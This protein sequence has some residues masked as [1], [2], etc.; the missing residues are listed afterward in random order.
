ML[1]PLKGERGRGKPAV[2]VSRSTGLD[3]GCLSSK[4]RAVGENR[5]A[6]VHRD[7]RRRASGAD[8]YAG[9]G[10]RRA[11]AGK[12]A[13]PLARRERFSVARWRNRLAQLA[14][15]NA[16]R[17]ARKGRPDRLLDL[18]LHQLAPL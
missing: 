13:G 7:A 15:A 12:L 11:P 1:L 6:R 17:T 18:Y 4:W 5:S 10:Q 3:E 2:P 8:W 14:T 9:G 16:C